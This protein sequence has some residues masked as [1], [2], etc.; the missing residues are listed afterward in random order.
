[1]TSIEARL[2]YPTDFDHSS[3]HLSPNQPHQ[4]YNSLSPKGPHYDSQTYQHHDDAPVYADMPHQHLQPTYQS[5]PLDFAYDMY[6]GRQMYGNNAVELES[7]C[8]PV[9]MDG[10]HMASYI[11]S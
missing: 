8:V 7:M 6:H 11:Q 9:S 3:E 5:P 4:Q 10:I 2:N 1:M